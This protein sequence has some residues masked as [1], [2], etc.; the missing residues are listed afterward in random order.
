MFLDIII[1]LA[2]LLVIVAVV[3]V[4]KHQP[5]TAAAPTKA[6]GDTLAAAAS[7][8]W[9]AVKADLPAI[10]S[11]EV[12]Q[13]RADRADLLKQLDDAKAALAAEVQASEARLAA[14]ADQVSTVVAGI[15]GKPVSALVAPAVAA[16]QAEDVA[17]VNA[18]TASLS[19]AP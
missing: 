4:A 15:T 5:P 3:Y 9:E 19:P 8:S 13:L 7:E 17:A 6:L 10:I 1:G 16:A 18:V 14:V 2:L 12:A 11:A